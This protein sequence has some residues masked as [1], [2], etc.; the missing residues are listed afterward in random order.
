[1]ATDTRDR[2]LDALQD[3]LVA[4]G[5]GAVTL[6]SVAATAGVSKGGLLYH[7]RSK[8]AMLHGLVGRLAEEAAAEF[9]HAQ[10]EGTD[11]VEYFL[12]TSF[13][14]SDKELALYW[15]VFAAL[16]GADELGEEDA[17]LLAGVFGQWSKLL[18]DYIGDPVLAEQVRLVGDGLYLSALA[19]LPR[20]DPELL[21]GVFQRLQDQVAQVRS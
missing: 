12:E 4:K 20:P 3:I 17:A 5:A 8:Q 21:R 2:I 7:F 18:T 9:A 11:V 6:E 15:S 14:Q 13:P 16:R 1:M 10:E 19:G